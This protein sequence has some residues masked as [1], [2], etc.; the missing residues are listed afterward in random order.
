MP[1]RRSEK[2]GRPMFLKGGERLVERYKRRGRTN[3]ISILNQGVG[4]VP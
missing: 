4:D 2:E 1:G 3:V